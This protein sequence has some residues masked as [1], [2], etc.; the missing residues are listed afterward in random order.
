MSIEKDKGKC[1]ITYFQAKILA[2]FYPNERSHKVFSKFG[3][4]DLFDIF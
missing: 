3:G 1:G 4:C 2:I